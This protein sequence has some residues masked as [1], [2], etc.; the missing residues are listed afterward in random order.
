MAG[1]FDRDAYATVAERLA[2]FWQAHKSGIVTTEVLQADDSIVRVK[3]IVYRDQNQVLSTGHAEELRG[4]RDDK[5][6]E[7]CESSA[8]GRALALGGFP[9]SKNIASREEM[10]SFHSNGGPVEVQFPSAEEARQEAAAA[11][12]E[13]IG[14]ERAGE[15]EGYVREWLGSGKDSE[16]R[17]EKLKL[18]LVNLGVSNPNAPLIEVLGQIP[19][20]EKAAELMTWLGKQDNTMTVEEFADALVE[21]GVAVERA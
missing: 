8:V 6:L 3:A 1:R 5:V 19:T 7:K 11:K 9:A 10:E 18:F 13:A 20:A 16:A 4:K 12:V 15:I 17:R 14:P 2:Q 21:E